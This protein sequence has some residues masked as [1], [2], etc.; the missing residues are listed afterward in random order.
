MLK[1][2]EVLQLKNGE[3]V[4]L[5]AKRHG[6]TILPGLFVAF[7][8]IVIPFFFLFPLF[9]SG[10]AGAVV[11]LVLILTG[12]VIAWR[13]FAMWDGDALI[14]STCRLVKVVQTGIFSRTVNEIPLSSILEVS[15]SK[16]GIGSH[17]FN[18]GVVRVLAGQEMLIKKV[19]QPQQLHAL[20]M[21]LVD[22]AKRSPVSDNH[23]REHRIQKIQ[24]MLNSMDDRMLREVERVL[25]QGERAETLQQVLFQD[26]KPI[27][28]NIVHAPTHQ[29][30]HQDYQ[31]H[32]NNMNDQD[33]DRNMVS[34]GDGDSEIHIKTLFGEDRT[35]KLK[36][37]DE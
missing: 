19:P 35:T 16:K 17:V 14:I 23:L 33:I 1:L 30:Y 32:S 18:Y 3:D 25:G 37:M 12:L 20:I 6:I 5:I 31:Y 27:H 22:V 13:T 10:P 34:R 7:L 4:R 29:E 2:E 8:F 26:I 36:L 21:D 9:S 15:W 24:K 11:F 28:P